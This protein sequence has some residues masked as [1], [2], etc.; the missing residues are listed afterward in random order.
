[1]QSVQM[2][3]EDRPYYLQLDG[4]Q[5]SY[6]GVPPEEQWDFEL[7]LFMPS[8][9]DVRVDN[10]I[11]GEF[12]QYLA[13]SWGF[14][15]LGIRRSAQTCGLDVAQVLKFYVKDPQKAYVPDGETR[16]SDAQ[17]STLRQIANVRYN[18]AGTVKIEA[19][20][21]DGEVVAHKATYTVTEGS[22]CIGEFE[23][24]DGDNSF[25]VRNP[26]V[27]QYTCFVQGIGGRDQ[28]PCYTAD[29]LAGELGLFLLGAV[30][31][32]DSVELHRG[33]QSCRSGS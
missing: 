28:N 5:P 19:S 27:N 32:P 33:A 24:R 9:G 4:E 7:R 30:D 16:P 13:T 10:K 14:S 26:A 3:D 15:V 17:M 1:M 23:R 8:D 6:V 29:W 31:E 20:S 12:E 18:A 11:I 2:D 25:R 21:L 22:L